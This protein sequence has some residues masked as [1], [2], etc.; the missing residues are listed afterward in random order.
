[1]SLLKHLGVV[2]VSAGLLAG[3]GFGTASA[4]SRGAGLTIT[5]VSNAALT[6]PT[7]NTYGKVTSI[8]GRTLTLD[9]G[10]RHIAFIVEENTDVLARGAGRATRK[11][12]GTLPIT[13]LVHSGDLVRV[14]YRE[15][16]G[17]LRASEIQIR[18]RNVVASR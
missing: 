16:D 2:G 9:V 4:Q 5:P 10:G 18:G 13:D 3:G 15:L 14:S 12:G 1:M 8:T 17:A 6:A 11:A 7:R